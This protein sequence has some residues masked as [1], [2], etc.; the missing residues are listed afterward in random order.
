MHIMFSLLFH[1]LINFS[2]TSTVFCTERHNCLLKPKKHFF[3][4]VNSYEA[5]QLDTTDLTAGRLDVT[6]LMPRTS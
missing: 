5:G 4:S 1:K 3:T 2:Y 6:I